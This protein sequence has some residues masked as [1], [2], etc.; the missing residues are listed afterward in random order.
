MLLCQINVVTEARLYPKWTTDAGA[1][2]PGVCSLRTGITAAKKA[3]N[4]LHDELGKT[5]FE[6]VRLVSFLRLLS[7]LMKPMVA[8]R[9][10]SPEIYS[11]K[12][13]EISGNLFQSFWKFS[14]NL[15]FRKIS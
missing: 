10:V 9:V 8:T 7:A 13:P 4:V 11:G 14:G 1:K 2:S 12:C 15:Y 3:I 6:Q 5:G